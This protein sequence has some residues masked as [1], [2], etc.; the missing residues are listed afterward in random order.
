VRR[1]T[2]TGGG[3][4]RTATV[5]RG[6]GTPTGTSRYKDRIAVRAM[7]ATPMGRRSPSFRAR[8]GGCGMT[9]G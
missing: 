4:E 3:A 1:S 2:V 5:A 9:I 6:T 8:I 7:C